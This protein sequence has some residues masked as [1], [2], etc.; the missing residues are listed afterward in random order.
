MVGN[1]RNATVLF[2]E[3]EMPGK[4]FIHI[5]IQFQFKLRNFSNISNIFFYVFSFSNIYFEFF[6]YSNHHCLYACKSAN[7]SDSD[8]ICIGTQR[9]NS[10][11]SLSVLLVIT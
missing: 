10:M 3:L 11:T 7:V 1:N 8:I 6:E 2:P 4:E 9:Y 5:L